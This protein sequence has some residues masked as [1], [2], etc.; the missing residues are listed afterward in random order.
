MFLKQNFEVLIKEVKHVFIYIN[1]ARKLNSNYCNYL[2]F[3]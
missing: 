2:F 3:N 1:P